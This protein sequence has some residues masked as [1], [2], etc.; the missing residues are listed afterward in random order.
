MY[1]CIHIYMYMYIFIYFSFIYSLIY[2]KT[3]DQPRERATRRAI[4]HVDYLKL[5]FYNM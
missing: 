4:D 5:Y 3:N 2:K 1:L